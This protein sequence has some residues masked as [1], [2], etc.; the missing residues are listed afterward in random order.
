MV[1]WCCVLWVCLA[2][3]DLIASWFVVLVGLAVY[4]LFGWVCGGLLYAMGFGLGLLD[5]G[6]LFW[7]GLRACC[8]LI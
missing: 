2:W 3:F 6:C 7:A 5:L 4:Y 1:D 8:Y